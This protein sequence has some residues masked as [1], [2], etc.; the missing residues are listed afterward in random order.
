M[1][2]LSFDTTTRSVHVALLQ[3]GEVVVQHEGSDPG[4]HDKN[5]PR[6][7][8]V[9]SLLPAIDDALRHCHWA[10]N[11]IDCIVV[12]SGPGSFTGIRTGVVTARTL[13][14]ALQVGL[15]PVSL[16]ECYA[17]MLEL[18]V[19]VVVCAGKAHH[20]V[21]GFDHDETSCSSLP[22]AVATGSL[23]FIANLPFL[24]ESIPAQYLSETQM[25]DCLGSVPRWALEAEAGAVAGT[26]DRELVELPKVKNIAVRQAQIAWNRLSL[27][28]SWEQE[29]SGK[30]FSTNESGNQTDS[31][32]RR[33]LS[34]LFPYQSVQPLYLRS[35]S[36]TVKTPPKADGTQN[37]ANAPGRPK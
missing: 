3:D 4:T 31:R 24:K 11:S 15:M 37:Q 30:V 34:E 22:T 8:V 6:Q 36:V 35:P 14:Q 25:A 1:R 12:G 26:A 19:A 16:L 10:K 7:E 32:L 23:P 17:S 20:F 33:R 13:A 28:L 2:L 29:G 5:G 27:R 9:T 21:A 18:P